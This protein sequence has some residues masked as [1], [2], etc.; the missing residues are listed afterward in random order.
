M[1]E[2]EEEQNVVVDDEEEFNPIISEVR[3]L[4][5]EPENLESGSKMWEHK[6]L[7]EYD[8]LDELCE[9]VSPTQTRSQRTRIWI[10]QFPRQWNG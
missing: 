2:I 1:L 4:A 6:L 5:A 10:T 8:M 9:V 7:N 3:S